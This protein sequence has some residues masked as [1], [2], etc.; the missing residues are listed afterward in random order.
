MNVRT[1]RAHVLIN[2][3]AVLSSTSF[4]TRSAAEIKEA[5]GCYRHAADLTLSSACR[6][7]YGN[8][9]DACDKVADPMLAEAKAE[10]AAARKA[11]EAE[12]T[13]A[14]KVAEAKAATAADELLAEEEK[15]KEQA[16]AKNKAGNGK[17]KG[18]KGKGKRS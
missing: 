18:K 6:V 16:A 4:E 2:I 15:E 10:A 13:E 3:E 12:A 1:M 8:F 7:E 5:A 14:R 11:A 9:A 17:G